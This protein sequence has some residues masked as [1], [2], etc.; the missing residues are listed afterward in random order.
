MAAV[1]GQA[2]MARYAEH[3]DPQDR[4]TDC[5][6][7]EHCAAEEA[8]DGG[9]AEEAAGQ[10]AIA[11]R[12]VAVLTDQPEVVAKLDQMIWARISYGDPASGA[13]H[14]RH[15][16]EVLWS[17]DADYEIDGVVMYRPF[18]PQIGD[19]ECERWPSPRGVPRGILGDIETETD[20]RRGER[21][22]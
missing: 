22:L 20:D 18:G 1:R 2:L 10:F 5:P 3:S 11:S 12:L 21:R 15:L 17:K 16:G 6:T 7:V 14:A 19:G 8:M 9:R 13:K 4:S